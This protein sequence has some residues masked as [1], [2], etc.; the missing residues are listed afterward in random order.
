MA[1]R[2]LTDKE[3]KVI[4]TFDDARPGL[5]AI[6]EQTIRNENSGWKEIIEEMKEEDI[7]INK[8]NE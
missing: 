2:Q 4:E 6:A 7:K 3:I 5:G 1:D 8:S